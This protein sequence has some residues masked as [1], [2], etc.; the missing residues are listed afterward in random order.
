MQHELYDNLP[1]EV[2]P[3][4]DLL[5]EYTKPEEGPLIGVVVNKPGALMCYGTNKN[6]IENRLHNQASRPADPEV[7]VCFSDD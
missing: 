6:D 4:G 1:R 5:I 3:S 2:E 7:D